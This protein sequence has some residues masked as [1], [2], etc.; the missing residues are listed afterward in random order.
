MPPASFWA[1]LVDFQIQI[2]RKVQGSCDHVPKLT[3][4]LL[5]V[6]KSLLHSQI[7]SQTLNFASLL[8]PYPGLFQRREKLIDI[9][10][11][12]ESREPATRLF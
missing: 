12:H 11:C 1:Q 4:D 2:V 5:Y 3:I 10:L 6:G 7:E 8:S 9:I